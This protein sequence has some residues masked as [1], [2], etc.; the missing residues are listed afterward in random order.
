MFGV[1]WCVYVD[2]DGFIFV[3]VKIGEFGYDVV[4]WLFIYD[5][6]KY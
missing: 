4:I 5:W 3:G 6:M 2:G 1:C